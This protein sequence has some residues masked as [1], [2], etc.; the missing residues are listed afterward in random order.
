MPS[1][2]S[3]TPRKRALDLSGGGMFAPAQEARDQRR[4]MDLA[5][6]QAAARTRPALELED[7]RP[8]MV[9]AGQRDANQRALA[10]NQFALNQQLDDRRRQAA[11]DL[12]AS[13]RSW[14]QLNLAGERLDDTADWRGTQ[15]ELAGQKTENAAQLGR[16]KLQLGYD[17][18]QQ[19]AFDN[20][21][22]RAGQSRRD[23]SATM[24]ALIGQGYSMDSIVEAMATGDFKQLGQPRPKG[25]PLDK[26]TAI[27]RFNDA[28]PETKLIDFLTDA[29][30]GGQYRR[31]NAETGEEEFDQDAALKG[32][33][34]NKAERKK[35]LDKYLS[36][37]N[38][39]QQQGATTAAAPA[40]PARPAAPAQGQATASVQPNAAMPS[41]RQ[42]NLD[43]I[44]PAMGA[45]PIPGSSLVGAGLAGLSGLAGMAGMTGRPQPAIPAAPPA[46]P[47]APPARV[48]LAAT[49]APV[50]APPTLDG[51]PLPAVGSI[52]GLNA[53]RPEDVGMRSGA[54][55]RET[56]PLKVGLFD[57]GNRALGQPGDPGME[58][59]EAELRRARLY[60]ENLAQ[61]WP[62]G[63]PYGDQ[64]LDLSGQS[65]RGDLARLQAMRQGIAGERGAIAQARAF[66][67]MPR[68]PQ[69]PYESAYREHPALDARASQWLKG[70]GVDPAEVARAYPD[71]DEQA[72]Y[73]TFLQ[74]KFSGIGA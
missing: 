23:A 28:V 19:R 56:A 6:A 36:E 73:L 68:L 38:Q 48:N 57:V 4:A 49:A 70:M 66:D 3:P 40:I 17:Q 14:A 46:A 33:Q 51:W 39:D 24:R 26:Y 35:A 67:A 65:P 18:L 2:F 13:R 71:P 52:E 59:S 37:I 5:G 21:Q 10:N 20:E 62:Q 12:D 45:L 53:L 47:P 58:P 9:A 42:L 1:F 7:P 72:R 55:V 15:A 41:T 30:L 31:K 22:S 74:Q 54:P 43:G 29:K 60:N 8:S 34:E 16:D 50:A 44:V 27:K 63:S 61:S 11:L 69:V 25:K 64:P 32:Y